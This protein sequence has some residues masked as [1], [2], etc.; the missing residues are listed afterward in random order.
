M[1]EIGPDKFQV[2]GVSSANNLLCSWVENAAPQVNSG[3][4]YLIVGP[5]STYQLVGR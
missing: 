5:D 2:V 3:T 1:Y 4:N